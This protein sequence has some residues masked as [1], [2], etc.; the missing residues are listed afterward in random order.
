MYVKDE[1]VGVKG[2]EGGFLQVGVLRTL[3]L[4]FLKKCVHLG[5]ILSAPLFLTY[6]SYIRFIFI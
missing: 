4:F 6:K 3:N 2:M 1:E 5:F